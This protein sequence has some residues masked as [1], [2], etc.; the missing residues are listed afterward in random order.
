MKVLLIFPPQW[1]PFQP[2]LSVPSLTGYLKSKGINVVQKDLNIEAYDTFFSEKY[3]K[4]LKPRLEE[5]FTALKARESLQPGLEQ[6]FYSDLFKAGASLE[7]IAGKV[8]GAKR[9][10]RSSEYYNAAKLAEAKRTL[11]H[12]LNVISSAYF[13]AWLELAWF[14]T[15]LF[16]GSYADVKEITASRDENP[17]LEIFRQNFLPYLEQEDPDLIGISVAGDSQLIPALTLSRLIK[18]VNKKAHVVVGGYVTSLLN[19]TITKHD[20]LLE[21]FFDSA[22][23]YEGEKPLEELAGRIARGQSLEDVPNLVYREGGRIRINATPPPEPIDSL[24]T[25][26]FDGLPLKLYLSPRPVLPLL[27]SRG[28]Y[29]GKCAFCAHNESYGWR[30]QNR[31]AARVAADMRE[32]SLKH[33]AS[34]F[35]FSDEGMSPSEMDRLCG[36]IVKEKMKV[37]C[38]TN[39][40]L[41]TKF[42]PELCRK[43]SEAGF[44]MLY[45]GLESGSNR[46]LDHMKKGTT[47]ETAARVCRNVHDAGIWNH[48]YVFFGFPTETRQ[49]ASETADFLFCNRD[50]I[51][52]F[53]IGH[54]ILSKGSAVMRCPEEYG[55]TKIKADPE[56]DFLLTFNYEVSS[57]LTTGQAYELSKTCWNELV[58]SYENRETLQQ[59]TQYDFLL[60][61]SYYRKSDPFLRSIKAK[62]VPPKAGVK[63]SMKSV[64]A[65]R[66]G[67]VLD[68]VRYNLPRILDNIAQGRNAVEHQE[69]TPIIFDPISGK[70]MAIAPTAMEILRLIDGKRNVKQIINKI[71]RKYETSSSAKVIEFLVSVL[72]A[73][74]LNV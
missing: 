62:A 42:T 6:E 14:T 8:E 32:L 61:L 45:L 51:C 2:Y 52:S 54:F 19:D 46:V 21:L 74:F 13:P 31:N 20:E 53:N 63:I 59:L 22:I 44:R 17:Y 24:P 39:V 3:L 25:P 16:R 30:Y 70:L 29:W 35:S 58:A 48:L 69:V 26:C 36:E 28:C 64:P 18:S 67:I 5:R 43:A 33:G 10:F 49:E 40:R 4:G 11:E 72:N 38:S 50:S 27:S 9:V 23:L 60:Y 68:T 57:G 37:S 7:Y 47:R 12:A 55:I 56:N 41:E 66:S 34:H 1:I 71:S 73:G 15:P 65:I